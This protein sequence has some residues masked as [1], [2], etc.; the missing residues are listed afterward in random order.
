MKEVN[1]DIL[2]TKANALAH[3][4]AVDD[5]F[6]HGVGGKLK[7]MWP[8]LYKDFRHF[9]KTH[10]PKP[11]DVWAWKGPGSP[12]IFNLFTQDRP[13]SSG[14]LP[15][16]AAIS[17]VHHALKKLHKELDEQ[18]IKSVAIT[19]I[20][21]GV[22]GLAWE[23]VKQSVLKDLKDYSGEVYIYEG[24]KPDVKAQE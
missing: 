23:E 21:T 10:S 7:E 1:G 2:L 11:G 15:P 22:G 17:D 20:A 19:K 14:Q 8:A 9:C 5:D 13:S 4:V 6:K 3:G 18:K 12:V 16:K 24:Y